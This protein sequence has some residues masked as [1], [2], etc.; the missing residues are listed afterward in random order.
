MDAISECEQLIRSSGG[1]E[2]EAP[3]QLYFRKEIFTPWHD[4]ELDPIATGLIYEQIIRSV[5]ASHFLL[6]II[7][8]VVNI[9]IL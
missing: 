3:W 7:S 2:E 5:Q 9:Y 8:Y 4:A 1:L 6:C